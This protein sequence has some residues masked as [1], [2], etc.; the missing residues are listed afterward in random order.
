MPTPDHKVNLDNAPPVALVFLKGGVFGGIQRKWHNYIQ[1]YKRYWEE[2]NEG[3]LLQTKPDES[4]GNVMKPIAQGVPLR[5]VCVVPSK[6][7]QNMREWF[8]GIEISFEFVDV[9]TNKEP[10]ILQWRR[11]IK[12]YRPVNVLEFRGP[13]AYRFMLAAWWSGVPSRS[14]AV[15]QETYSYG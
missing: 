10:S 2:Y 12:K 15:V 13:K 14:L 4:K 5:W 9:G 7:E 11:L 1:W 8:R 6:D 3:G